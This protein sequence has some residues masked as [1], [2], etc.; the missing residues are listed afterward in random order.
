MVKRKLAVLGSIGLLIAAGGGVAL[1][2]GTRLGD[3]GR[4]TSLKPGGVRLS[5]TFGWGGLSRSR[6]PIVTGFGLWFPKGSQYNGSRYPKCSE[7][8]LDRG[9]PGA[10]PSGS[11][12]GS[13]SGIAYAASAIT[14]PKITIVN[15]GSED[16]YVVMN[17]PARVRE[18]VDGHI[19]R[20]SGKFAYHLDVKIPKNLQIVAGTPIKLTSLRI[21]AGKGKW[22]AITQAPA[23][24]Q[25]AT[26]Y[27]TGF[28]TSYLV[29]V[30]NS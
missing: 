26:S 15:G 17:N 13:G 21:T 6:Q 5:T 22:L 8:T 19:T 27:S 29:W 14:R 11:V 9:G 3:H 16:V 18:A 30:H 2:T 4:P 25:V 12:M 7:A 10:C 24:I 1:A 28:Q 20:A 23:G